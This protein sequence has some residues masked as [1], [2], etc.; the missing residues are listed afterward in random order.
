MK[1]K[2][3]SG[4]RN[5]MV[6]RELRKNSRQGITEISLE[7]GIPASTVFKA[8]R[9]LEKDIIRRYASSLEYRRIGY[10]I[11]VMIAVAATEKVQLKSF[12]LAEKHVNT[13]FQATDEC[14]FI[15]EALFESM[16]QLSDFLEGLA[17]NGSS[18]TIC[19][20]MVEELKKEEFMPA[21]FSTALAARGEALGNG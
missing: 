4:L 13:V 1:G 5:L 18:E 3:D 21:M 11:R 6:L 19:Y 17:T 16:L 8:V 7:T 9:H 12:L 15:I 2:M 20:F 10:P 14:D